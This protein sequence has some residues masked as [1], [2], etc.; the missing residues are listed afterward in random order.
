MTKKLLILLLTFFWVTIGFVSISSALLITNY[1]SGSGTYLGGIVGEPDG[2][3]RVYIGKYSVASPS[4]GDFPDNH[5]KDTPGNVNVILTKLGVSPVTTYDEA[6]YGGDI[7]DGSINNLTGY[8]LIS[9]KWDQDNG[10]WYVWDLAGADKF[11]FSGLD[12]GLS[13]VRAWDTD[14]TPPEIPIPEPATMLL[15]GTGLVGLAG[16]TRKKLKK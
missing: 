15:L 5:Q 2:T 4:L 6:Q 11:T 13:H 16:M 14:G 3:P 7:R 9:L 10:G 1:I 8:E 12:R